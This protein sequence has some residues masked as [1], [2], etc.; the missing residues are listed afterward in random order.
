MD[1]YELALLESGAIAAGGTAESIQELGESARKG[2][3]GQTWMMFGTVGGMFIGQR[4]QNPRWRN[5]APL[6]GML[7]GLALNRM[8]D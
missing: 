2:W 5:A 1:E 7:G 3:R 8:I 6:L 4:A